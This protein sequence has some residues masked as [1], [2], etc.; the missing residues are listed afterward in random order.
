MKT[1]VNKLIL[2]LSQILSNCIGKDMD[3]E[4][5]ALLG[6]TLLHMHVDSC[7]PVIQMASKDI[8]ENMQADYGWT[9]P[10]DTALSLG[11]LKHQTYYWNIVKN[12]EKILG[13]WNKSGMWGRNERDRPR[14][15]AT[16]RVF[17][18]LGNELMKDGFIDENQ[19]EQEVTKIWGRDIDEVGYIFKASAYLYIISKFKHITNMGL[20][21]RTI[22]LIQ[23]SITGEK[24]LKYAYMSTTGYS[25]LETAAFTLIALLQWRE[26]V[27]AE[28]LRK[29]VIL[30]ENELGREDTYADYIGLSY[31]GLAL[32]EYMEK[33]D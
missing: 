2:C 20:V 8:I 21:L 7:S 26:C 24:R 25:N 13:T 9:C 10:Y 16:S 19:T 22:E 4:K 6:Y 18:F 31:A 14:L 29:L 1:T 27:N 28:F 32:N 15:V 33:M 23:N 17:L 3:V 30:I 11:V 12:G 5:I